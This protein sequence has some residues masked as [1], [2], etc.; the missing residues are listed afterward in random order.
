MYVTIQGTVYLKEHL[1]PVND[2]VM[3][4]ELMQAVQA[5]GRITELD[6]VAA[7]KIIRHWDYYWY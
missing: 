4:I 3:N 5:L 1:K 7:E 6:M 2:L